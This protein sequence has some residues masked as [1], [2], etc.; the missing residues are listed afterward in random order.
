[1]AEAEARYEPE[2]AFEEPGGSAEL[3]ATA[4][5]ETGGSTKLAEMVYG[6]GAGSAA[7]TA[8][9]I[10]R[11]VRVMMVRGS[12]GAMMAGESQNCGRMRHTHRCRRCSKWYGV[13]TVDVTVRSTECHGFHERVGQE[14]ISLFA[15]LCRFRLED[16]EGHCET[17]CCFRLCLQIVSAATLCALNVSPQPVLTST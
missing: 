17:P 11:S 2:A 6:M 15:A 8:A 1:M 4:V 12:V 7:A 16:V 5:A 14:Q 13:C 10:L 9:M 3:P